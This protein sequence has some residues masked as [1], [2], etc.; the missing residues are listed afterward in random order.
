[1]DDYNILRSKG[2]IDESNNNFQTKNPVYL[3]PKSHLSH[4]IIYK[5]HLNNLHSST[6]HTLSQLRKEYWVPRGRRTVISAIKKYCMPCRKA[7]SV[8]FK[9]LEYPS[10][11]VERVC[12]S[13]PFEHTGVDYFGPINIKVNGVVSKIWVCLYTCLVVRA[14]HL[15][16]VFNLS[17]ACFINSFKR[18]V[19]RHSLPKSI[20]SDNG[21]QFMLSEKAFKTYLSDNKIEWH[22]V[23]E[24]APWKGGFYERMIVLVKKHITKCVGRNI[25]DFE[26]FNTLINKIE[27]IINLRPITYVSESPNE[28]ISLRPIDFLNSNFS[29]LQQ[30]L[31]MEVIKDPDYF[32]Q[33]TKSN[34]LTEQLQRNA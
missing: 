15:E 19:A 28:P 14:I 23:T 25:L 18:F 31:D 11:P 2:R 32:E 6:I 1:M 29:D 8:P 17:A 9:P 26:Y 20:W 16:L 4:L 34:D 7:S 5:V 27:S 21:T 10:L 24:K 30:L 12:E 3:H 13:K 33:K 22:F